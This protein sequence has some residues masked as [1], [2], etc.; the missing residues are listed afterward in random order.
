V[1]NSKRETQDVTTEFQCDEW[2]PRKFKY[3]YLFQCKVIGF[4]IISIG[5]MMVELRKLRGLFEFKLS[6]Q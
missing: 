6:V 5:T 2:M 4:L 1:R 3:Y